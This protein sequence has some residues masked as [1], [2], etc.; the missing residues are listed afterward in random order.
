TARP[1]S[2]AGARLDHTRPGAPAAPPPLALLAASDP[3]NYDVRGGLPATTTDDYDLNGDLIQTVAADDTDGSPANNSQLPSGTSTGG[4]SATT[5][6]D[7]NQSWM[8]GQWAGRTVLIITGTGAGQLRTIVS[9]AAHQPTVPTPWT[10]IPDATSV[11]AFQGD[12][13]RYVYDGFNRLTSV[14]D[15]VGNQTV[16]QYDPA[17]DVVRTLHFGPVGGPSPTTD[18]P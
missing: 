2:D 13:T 18:G 12:R 16:Y 9:S 15:A 7:T 5:L 10:T 4:N 11:Y 6:V 1:P 17:G 8:T 3:R 14:V